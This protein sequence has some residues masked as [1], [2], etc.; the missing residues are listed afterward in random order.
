MWLSDQVPANT[1]DCRCLLTQI[2]ALH[3][4]REGAAP[5]VFGVVRMARTL[6]TCPAGKE[7]G[8]TPVLQRCSHPALRQI[9]RGFAPDAGDRHTAS[10]LGSAA[11]RGICRK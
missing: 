2:A 6:P 10:R 3:R 4:P 9:H 5:L 7:A 11:V 8:T 1:H